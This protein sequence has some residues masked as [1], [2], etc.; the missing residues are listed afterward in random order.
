MALM[1]KPFMNPFLLLFYS[2]K[3]KSGEERIKQRGKNRRQLLRA[4]IRYGK[5]GSDISVCGRG[6][7]EKKSTLLKDKLFLVC[8]N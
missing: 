6:V 8:T 3:R 4:R 1:M 2:E 5:T 7:S